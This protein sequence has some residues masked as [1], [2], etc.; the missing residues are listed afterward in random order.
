MLETVNIL[1]ALTA[2]AVVAV[3]FVLFFRETYP[4]EVV[5]IIGVSL[6]LISGVLPYDQAR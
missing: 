3:M 5:A 4:A 2:L 1:P 6:L